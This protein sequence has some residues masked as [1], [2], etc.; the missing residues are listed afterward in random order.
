[1]RRSL[2]F[3][4]ALLL[5]SPL[6]HAQDLLTLLR[7]NPERYANVHHSYE[8]PETIVDTPAPAGYEPF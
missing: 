6:A 7:E 4:A 3:L 1:M 5:L 8:A 2:L